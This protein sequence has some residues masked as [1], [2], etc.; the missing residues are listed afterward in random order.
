[1]NDDQQILYEYATCQI[2]QGREN[3]M[4]ELIYVIQIV[5]ILE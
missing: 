1:M 3:M 5:P 4:L 2:S